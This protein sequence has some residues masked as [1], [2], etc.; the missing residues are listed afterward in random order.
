MRG[1]LKPSVLSVFALAACQGNRPETGHDDGR[2]SAGHEPA[3]GP[4]QGSALADAA[5]KEPPAAPDLEAGTVSVWDA[6][7]WRNNYLARRGQHGVIVGKVGTKFVPPAVLVVPGVGPVLHH[8]GLE[9]GRR[10]TRHVTVSLLVVFKTIRLSGNLDP[11][12]RADLPMASARA[13]GCA[14]RSGHGI[15]IDVFPSKWRIPGSNR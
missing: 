15:R 12:E 14:R 8:P 13:E 9:A 2:G 6:V 11:P 1:W 4:G 3:T 7:V 5:R 10:K